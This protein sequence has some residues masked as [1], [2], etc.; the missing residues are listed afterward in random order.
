[1]R[2][3]PWPADLTIQVKPLP[4]NEAGQL[5]ETECAAVALTT[6]ARAQAPYPPGRL[7]VAGTAI[8]GLPAAVTGDVS[9]TWT[10]RN[11]LTQGAGVV[12]QDDATAF[13]IEGTLTK[14]LLVGGAVIGART[15]A[16][17]VGTAAATYTAAQRAA[18]DADGTKPM[19]FRLTP[20]NGAL[21]G[22]VRET[23]D[24]VMTG[25]GMTYGQ[26]YGGV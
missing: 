22:A 5:L 14:E 20:K 19:R 6:K 8:P 13:A 21:T 9:L 4:R 12:R 16:G 18:D 17:L 25:Y 15:E 26:Y 7:R 2:L 24:L 1:M 10:H 23:P 3:T 11:R